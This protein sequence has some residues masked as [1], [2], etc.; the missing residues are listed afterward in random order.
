M[1]LP[2]I[3]QL[4]RFINEKDEDFI[5]ETIETLEELSLNESLKDE[6]LDVLGELIS[7]LHGAIAVSESIGNGVSEREALNGFMKR[8]MGSIDKN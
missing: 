3:K 8:V 7:N 5:H 6:E 4:V 2:I 1:R